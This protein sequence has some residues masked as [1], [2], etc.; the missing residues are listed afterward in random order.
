MIYT[1]ICVMLRHNVFAVE[2]CPSFRLSLTIPYCGMQKE[3]YV[4]VGFDMYS[5]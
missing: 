3:F 2:R 4:A 5:S 1:F